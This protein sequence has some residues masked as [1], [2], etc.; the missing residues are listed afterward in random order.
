MKAQRG[1][2]TPDPILVAEIDAFFDSLDPL[3][4]LDDVLASEVPGRAAAA[5]E[6]LV[7][8]DLD[9]GE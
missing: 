4:L 6:Q 8:G 5:F 2:D 3:D 1:G 9:G 7:T